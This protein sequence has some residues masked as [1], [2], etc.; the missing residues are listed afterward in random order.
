MPPEARPGPHP[1]PPSDLENRRVPVREFPGPFYRLH[2]RDHEPLYFGATGENRFDDSERRFGVL[3][4]A[5]DELCAFIETY[6]R[7]TGTNTVTVSSIGARALAR[8]DSSRSLRLVDLPG[9]GAL[10][11]IGADARLTAGDHAVAQRWSRAFHELSTR[12]DGISYRPRHDPDRLAVALFDRVAP[13]LNAT[14][15]GSLMEPGNQPLLGQIL[16]HYGFALIAD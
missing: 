12:P 16:D 11:R 3:Y 1:E 15:L 14:N 13:I 2:R 7:M 9:P 8:I 6:G 10:P 4:A 5:N